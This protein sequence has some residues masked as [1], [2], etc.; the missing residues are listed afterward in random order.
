MSEKEKKILESF[1]RNIPKLSD[2]QKEKVLIFS[3]ALAFMVE[4]SEQEAVADGGA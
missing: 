2:R 1:Q 3:E 4:R